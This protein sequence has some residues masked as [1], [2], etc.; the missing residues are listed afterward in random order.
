MVHKGTDNREE[1][2]HALNFVYD[3]EVVR[4]LTEI[5]F[6]VLELVKVGGEFQIEIYFFS[7]AAFKDFLRKG[8][9]SHLPWTQYA[10]NREFL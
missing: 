8:G 4:I 9:F 2:R 1:R 6:R 7:P 5:Q 3:H 10:D